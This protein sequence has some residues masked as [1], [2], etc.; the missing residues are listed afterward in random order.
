MTGRVNVEARHRILEVARELFHTRGLGGVSMEDVAGAAGIKKANLF[1]Y[2]HSKESLELAVLEQAAGEMKEQI[3][4]QLSSSGRDPVGA[5]ASMFD[6]AGRWMRERRCR[7]G[8]FLGNV[9]QEASDHNETIRL[10]VSE[11][12]HYW[13]EQIAASLDRARS[14]GYFRPDL[15]PTP[16]AE[17]ILALFEGALLFSKASRRDGPVESSKRMAVAYLQGFRA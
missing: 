12:L 2:Y 4:A 10:R 6:Q 5:V 9:A 13:M 11:L 8:C 7:G 16:A 14:A 3:R 1:H 17:A 15:E